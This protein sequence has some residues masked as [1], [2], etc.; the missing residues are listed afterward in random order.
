MTAY[1]NDRAQ[2]GVPVTVSI[3]SGGGTLNGTLTENTDATGAAV[4]T[5]L[6]I[7]GTVGPR[8][9]TFTSPG[10]TSVASGTIDVLVGTPTSIVAT[11]STILGG[12]V[13]QPV[14]NRPTVQVTDASGNPVVGVTVT[15]TVSSGGGSVTGASGPTGLGG[16]AQ[17]TSWTLGTV[18]GTNT[19]THRS[20]HWLRW[21]SRPPR[22]RAACQ[23]GGQHRPSATAQSGS[24]LGQQPAIQLQDQFGNG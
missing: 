2:A 6:E 21:L 7:I 17:V 23:V 24:V 20:R 14:S 13:G 1:G 5:N 19:S 12:T 9:L 22:R 15:F 10:L 4:F 3:T 18:A 16:I 8:S 11:T